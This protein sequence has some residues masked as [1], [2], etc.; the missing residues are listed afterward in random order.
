MGST[1][2]IVQYHHDEVCSSHPG[3]DSILHLCSRLRLWWRIRWLWRGWLWWIWQGLRRWLWRLRR[4][5]WRLWWIWRIWRI[6]EGLRWRLC[7]YGGGYGGYGDGYGYGG[8]G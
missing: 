3:C 2:C 7:G 4:R 1:S 5:L 6:W 8:Y